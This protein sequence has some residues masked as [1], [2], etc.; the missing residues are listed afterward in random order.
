MISGLKE[1]LK[2]GNP[3]ICKNLGDGLGQSRRHGGG[4]GGKRDNF[5]PPP[6]P[7]IGHPVRS[8][9]IRGDFHVGKNGDR[10]TVFAP[11]D[12]THGSSEGHE[13]YRV[14]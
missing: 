11:T 3:P 4:G 2:R 13:I 12:A 1:G 8:T 10:F 7:P 5:P 6:Q 9:Q 14:L